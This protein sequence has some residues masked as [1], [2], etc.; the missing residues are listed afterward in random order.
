[1]DALPGTVVGQSV[2]VSAAARRRSG[3]HH[4][5]SR[6]HGPSSGRQLGHDAVLV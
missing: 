1:M 5:H 6:W 3:Q 2:A 4:D